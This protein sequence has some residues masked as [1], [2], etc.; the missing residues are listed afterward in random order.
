MGNCGNCGHTHPST[1]AR[2]ATRISGECDQCG[3][4]AFRHGRGKMAPLATAGEHGHAL[5]T[6]NTQLKQHVRDLRTKLDGA[7]DQGTFS[8]AEF[9]NLRKDAAEARAE[10][11]RQSVEHKQALRAAWK[12]SK[13]LTE[14]V[15]QAGKIAASLVTITQGGGYSAHT[16]AAVANGAKQI[17]ELLSAAAEA[18]NAN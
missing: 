4:L 2:G 3:C 7:L 10:L 5:A 6:E 1:T 11:L 13:V 8:Q 16:H 15:K 18:V 9:D 14:A 17:D 12:G